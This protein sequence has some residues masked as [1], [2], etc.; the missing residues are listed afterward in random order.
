M[1]EMFALF[2]LLCLSALFSA[3]ETAMVSLSLAR[4]E[5]LMRE[6]RRGSA[7]LFKLKSEP[8]RMLIAIL[9][10]NNVANIAASALATVFATRHLGSIGPGVAVGILTL[11]VLIFAEITPKSIATRHAERISLLVAPLMAGF[12]WLVSPLV[13]VFMQ[14]AN[15][16]DR[17]E[18]PQAHEPQ[19]TESELISMVAYGEEEGTIEQQERQLIERAFTLTDLTVEDVMTPRQKIF[20]LD[21]SRTITE[22]LPALT[23]ARYSRIPLY[24]NDPDDISRVLHLRDLLPVVTGGEEVGSLFDLGRPAKFVPER[25]A[26]TETIA[27]FRQEQQHMAIVIDEH[28]TLKGLVTFEDLLEELV[29]EIYDESDELPREITPIDKNRALLDGSA[30]LRVLEEYFGIDLPGKPTDSVSRWLLEKLERIPVAEET[31]DF[32]GLQVQV[33]AASGRQIKQVIVERLLKDSG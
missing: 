33:K 28:G 31:F 7:A 22:L 30:E 10:G 15:I 14:I 32:D 18:G 25:Q 21:G 19:V 29:G 26:V 16:F 1:S 27:A 5:S 9:I 17:R 8:Q 2:I 13:W 3:S 23:Q 24:E 11:V 4:A 6:G 20:M 12:L